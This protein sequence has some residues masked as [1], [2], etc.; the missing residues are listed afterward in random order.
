MTIQVYPAV[1][2][3][4]TSNFWRYT[5]VG[6]ETTLT[7]VDNSGTQLYYYPNQEQVFLNGVLLVRG[8][9]YTAISG[10]S[11]T[12]LA[13]LVAGDTVQVNCY[14]NFTIT[15]VP[16]TSIQGS[17]SNLQLAN[18]SFTLGST[19]I[20]LGGT[21]GTISG[22]TL[23]SPTINTP[24]ISSPSQTN[25]IVSTSSS[26]TI[27]LVING[28]SGQTS[29]MLQIKATSS[30]SVLSRFDV[31][32]NLGLGT[33]PSVKL[34]VNGYAKI[35]VTS[36]DAILY[37]N[38]PND[39]ASY[40]N[41]GQAGTYNKAYI[42][43][44]GSSYTYLGGANSL[45]I[46]NAT[47]TGSIVFE[48]NATVVGY[49]NAAGQLNI[50]G[51]AGQSGSQGTGIYS[52]SG[53]SVSGTTTNHAYQGAYIEWNKSNGN[54]ETDFVNQKG[55]GGGGFTWYETTTG[56]SLTQHM[57][58][59]GNGNL[60]VSGNISS[61]G[62]T[63]TG[64]VT[65]G[66]YVWSAGQTVVGY[67]NTFQT[68]T[69]NTNVKI[70]DFQNLSDGLY[71]LWVS[72]PSLTNGSGG[73]QMY[74]DTSYGGVIGIAAAAV[75]FNGSP[76]ETVTLNNTH[77][78]LSSTSYRPTFYMYS[79]GFGATNGTGPSGSYG[80]LSLFVNFPTTAYGQVQ[81]SFKRLM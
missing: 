51:S 11:I 56:N 14:S 16:A 8:V 35:S 59:D 76:S 20:S 47:A 58:L 2:S 73:G 9:D 63:Y 69:A 27:P 57:N 54:G 25:S 4:V 32:G 70:A 12:G 55:N 79:D 71:A 62:G 44:G 29:D 77:H 13:A 39:S 34:D 74:W 48:T 18:S 66:T 30:G 21:S 72:W 5:A 23:T 6:G 15:Q 75:Y 43:L 1:K 24:I 3:Q 7:G 46:A 45:T 36:G 26:S 10:T 40:L 68:F 42:G 65:G 49:I 53:L 60:T 22:L 78:H 38:A 52:N 28:V 67:N 31:N 80:H 37:M 41:F 17:I 81:V 64:D 50:G 33:T 61:S 19:S